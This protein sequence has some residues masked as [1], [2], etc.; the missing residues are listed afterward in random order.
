MRYIRYYEVENKFSEEY[1]GEKY[2]EPWLSLTKNAAGDV[3]SFIAVTDP[4]G[5][6]AHIEKSFGYLGVGNSVWGWAEGKFFFTELPIYNSTISAVDTENSA[7]TVDGMVFSYNGETPYSSDK[8][9]LFYDDEIV[10][11]Q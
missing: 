4:Y 5:S 6:G 9:R 8:Y 7:I 2:I 1:H 10:I 3:K 11:A